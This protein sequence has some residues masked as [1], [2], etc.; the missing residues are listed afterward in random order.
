[1]NKNQLK[2]SKEEQK[3]AQQKQQNDQPK[4]YKQQSKQNQFLWNNY[5]NKQLK[6]HNHIISS[7]NRT[8]RIPGSITTSPPINTSG[9]LIPSIMIPS[10]TSLS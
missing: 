5:F 7:S 1:V 8:N 9:I 4:D 2:D 6:Q 3:E 10:I